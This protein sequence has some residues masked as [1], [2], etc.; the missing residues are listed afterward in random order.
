M[1]NFDIPLLLITFNRKDTV[2]QVFDEIKKIKPSKLYISSDGAR[3]N[4]SG[5]SSLVLEIRD[6]LLRNIDW[7]C[8]IRTLFREKNL[9]CKNAVFGAIDWFFDNEEM[10]IIL[11]DDTVPDFSFFNYCEE[12]LHKYKDDTR[13]GIIS[14]NNHINVK[15]HDGSSYLFSKFMF[16]WGWATWRRAWKNMKLNMEFLDERYKDSLLNNM[17]YSSRSINYWNNCIAAIYEQRVNTWDY[18]WIMSLRSQSQYCIFP[19]TNLVANI[20][21]GTASTHNKSSS[22]RNELFLKKNEIDFPLV[23]PDFIIPDY[24]FE[25]YYEKNMILIPKRINKIIPRFIKEFLK[26]VLKK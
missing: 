4:V 22:V 23:H 1:E 2:M 15:P 7:E 19:K 9:G 6:T 3:G 17:G 20:G 25:S 10:G 8:D 24:G 18:Q 5:E 13:I 14:G 21:F 16:I 26:K 11:E 12:L